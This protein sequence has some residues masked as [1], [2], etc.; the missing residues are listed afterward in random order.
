[1]SKRDIRIP[2]PPSTRGRVRCEIHFRTTLRRSLLPGLAAKP[3]AAARA[4]GPHSELSQRIAHRREA[5][6]V[7]KRIYAAF[8]KKERDRASHGQCWLGQAPGVNQR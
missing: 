2:T 8:L 4:P 5:G 1:M 7:H 3:T 6:T